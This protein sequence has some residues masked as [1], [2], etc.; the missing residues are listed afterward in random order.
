MCYE[1]VSLIAS[2]NRVHWF[3]EFLDSLLPTSVSYE[4]I[5]AGPAPNEEMERITEQYYPRFRYIH[6]ANIKPAQ[7]YEVARRAAKGELIHWTA[8]DAVYSEDCI[9]KAYKYWKSQNNEKL[10]LSIQTQE[11]YDKDGNIIL[12]DMNVHRFFGGDP[13]APLMAPLALIDREFLNKLGGF[14]R[15][16]L[17]GQ[18]ENDVVMNAYKAGARVEIWRGGTIRIDHIRKHGKDHYN[19]PFATGYPYDRMILEQTWFE[20]KTRKIRRERATPFEPYEDKDILTKSQSFRGKW[21]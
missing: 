20:P 12:A 11:Q 16:Y 21:I 18:Y 15:R 8:D 6:T 4:V 19:R 17:C 3:S 1:K 5:F 2:A 10:I 7:C 13:S 14:D 9:G